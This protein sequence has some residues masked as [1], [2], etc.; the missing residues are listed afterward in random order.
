MFST[1]L[2]I[3]GLIL[4]VAAGAYASMLVGSCAFCALY[5]AH[6][7]GKAGR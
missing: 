4:V 3:A 1:L 6:E 5:L 2:Q 7:M